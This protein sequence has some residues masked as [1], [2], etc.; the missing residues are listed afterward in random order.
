MD[1]AAPKSLD[2]N[3]HPSAEVIYSRGVGGGERVHFNKLITQAAAFF[4]SVIVA[5]ALSSVYSR[6]SSARCC[7]L[8]NICKQNIIEQE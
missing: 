3:A 5:A 8:L 1:R 6:Q 4:Y 2:K 7:G